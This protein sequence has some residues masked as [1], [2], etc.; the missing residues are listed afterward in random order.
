[1]DL[2]KRIERLERQ[3]RWLRLAVLAVLVLV[4][5]VVTLGA[6]PKVP[7]TLRAGRIELT[8]KDNRVRACLEVD[9]RGRSVLS[10]MDQNGKTRLWMYAE[11]ESGV[12]SFCDDKQAARMMMYLTDFGDPL[13]LFL[14]KD[15][16][17]FKK[18]P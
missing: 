13:V 17:V 15:R 6:Q 1:M 18:L 11:K 12:I 3:N 2:Q 14:D 9:A 8:D 4:G 7:A 16:D 10:L 5:T